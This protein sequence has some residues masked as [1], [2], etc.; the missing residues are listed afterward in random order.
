LKYKTDVSFLSL[1]FLSLFFF[2]LC[3]LL[4]RLVHLSTSVDLSLFKVGTYANY[5][6]FFA[7]CSIWFFFF[8]HRS[9][10]TCISILFV[11]IEIVIP[12]SRYLSE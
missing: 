3:L 5:Y 10:P 1:D 7:S 12:G 11:Y 4:H 9:E 8:D 2:K 6:F